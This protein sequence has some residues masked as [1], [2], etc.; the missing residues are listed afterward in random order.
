M[1]QRSLEM[2]PLFNFFESLVP[3]GLLLPGFRRPSLAE[4]GKHHFWETKH[5]VRGLGAPHCKGIG[6]EARKVAG[7]SKI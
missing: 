1:T 5:W 4:G 2:D 6:H 3:T 7:S